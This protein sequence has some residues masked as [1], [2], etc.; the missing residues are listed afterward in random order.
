M[1]RWDGNGWI[2]KDDD[3]LPYLEAQRATMFC[4]RM[5]GVLALGED[6]WAKVLEYR[7]NATWAE[8]VI[9][10][11]AGNWFRNS[12][13]IQFFGYLLGLTAVEMDDLFASAARITE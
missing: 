7:A 4:S 5:Q 13:N 12:E 11:D 10:D 6:R 3:L 1:A 9:I 2:V 8:K